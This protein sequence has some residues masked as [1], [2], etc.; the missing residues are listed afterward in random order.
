MPGRR[1]P[2]LLPAPRRSAPPLHAPHCYHL[3]T[4]HF[5]T[6]QPVRWHVARHGNTCYPYT[7]SAAR[8]HHL[9]HRL[10]N[11]LPASRYPPFPATGAAFSR[12]GRTRLPACYTLPSAHRRDKRASTVAERQAPPPTTSHTTFPST[13]QLSQYTASLPAFNVRAR[14]PRPPTSHS[15]SRVKQI[16]NLRASARRHAP[17]LALSVRTPLLPLSL[18]GSG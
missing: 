2:L 18:R 13:L 9:Q 17:R 1:W 12:V 11:A 6:M 16:V 8:H 15:A 4:C 10:A 14:L 3:L 5:S 7:C